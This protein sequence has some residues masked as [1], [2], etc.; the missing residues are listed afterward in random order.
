MNLAFDDIL[1]DEGLGPVFKWF[2]IISV[3]LHAAVIFFAVAIAP[4]IGGDSKSMKPVYKVNLITLPPAPPPAP[5]APSDIQV[6]PDAQTPDLVQ[7]PA[8]PPE[9]EATP[10][11][12][13]G[14]IKPKETPKPEVKKIETKPP[15]PEIKEIEKPKPKPKPEP[16]PEPKK[17]VKPKPKPV[18]KPKV[19]AD[20]LVNQKLKKIEAK[21]KAQKED[22]AINSAIAN[23]AARHTAGDGDSVGGPGVPGG[24]KSDIDARKG[25]Y[26]VILYNIVQSNW[27]MP[28]PGMVDD[29][30]NL[31]AIYVITIN[32]SGAIVRNRFDK[33]S[34][35]DAFDQAVERALEMSKLPPLPDVF[36]GKAVVGLRFTPAGVKRN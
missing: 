15:K 8:A 29:Q 32:E 2:I 5:A 20:Q 4:N 24:Q 18:E 22:K 11:V 23:L 16:K 31:M 25:A 28:P 12:P 10:L 36:G 33:K 14:P 7:V 6:N 30:D 27:V 21:V 35:Q 26:F 1:L 19:T 34:G 17:E 3:L 9:P 13:V